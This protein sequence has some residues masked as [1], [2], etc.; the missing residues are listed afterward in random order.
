[1]L[2]IVAMPTIKTYVVSFT[3]TYLRIFQKLKHSP[4]DLN[5][6]L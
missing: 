4:V 5:K 6:E 2:T 1:M 3:S